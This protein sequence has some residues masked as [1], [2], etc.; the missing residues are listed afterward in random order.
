MNRLIIIILIIIFALL[1]CLFTLMPFIN[2][3]YMQSDFIEYYILTPKPL[4]SAP[5]VTANWYFIS[6]TDEGS[7]QKI[8]SLIFTGIK[9]Q[10]LQKLRE[11]LDSYI[12]NYPDN[13]VIMSVSEEV[14]NGNVRLRLNYYDSF[15]DR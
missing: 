1:Y 6:Q 4:K 5:R 12:E 2:E 10:N 7:G 13:H 11:E 9:T 14:D 8:N 3:E 15:D